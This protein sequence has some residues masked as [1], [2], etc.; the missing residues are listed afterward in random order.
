MFIHPALE[1]I[2]HICKEAVAWSVPVYANIPCPHIIQEEGIS[3]Y[4][5][6]WLIMEDSLTHDDETGVILKMISIKVGYNFHTNWYL[7]IE[8]GFPFLKHIND[9]LGIDQQIYTELY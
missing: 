1:T 9:T 6:C 2:P 4:A 3:E 5:M 8:N 7:F